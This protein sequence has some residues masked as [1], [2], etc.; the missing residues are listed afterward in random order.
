MVI[1]QSSKYTRGTNL[2]ARNNGSLLDSRW[3]L[4]TIGVDPSEELL[5]QV[6]VVEV[7]TDLWKGLLGI[8]KT[9]GFS[10]FTH[11]VPVG[12]DNTV[13][14]HPGGAVILSLLLGTVGVPLIV[15]SNITHDKSSVKK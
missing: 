6:H 1:M 14:V 7:L 15:P 13:G 12:V 2:D 3:L 10:L 11:L 5:L 9:N 4:E 8:C